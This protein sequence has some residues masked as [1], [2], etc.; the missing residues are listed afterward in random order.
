MDYLFIIFKHYTN[1]F[2]KTRKLDYT[3]L[4]FNK[5]SLSTEIQL[6]DT[7]VALENLDCK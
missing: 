1:S 3:F 5:L 2:I 7:E 4:T 6:S